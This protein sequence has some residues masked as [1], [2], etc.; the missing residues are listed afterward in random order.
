MPGFKPVAKLRPTPRSAFPCCC[1]MFFNFQSGGE[2]GDVLLLILKGRYAG[3][4]HSPGRNEFIWSRLALLRWVSKFILLQFVGG[5][6]SI[7]GP[8]APTA[9]GA[10][11]SIL[12]RLPIMNTQETKYFYQ[13]PRFIDILSSANYTLEV[14]SRKEPSTFD[15]GVVG[16]VVKI[17]LPLEGLECKI[18]VGRGHR[19]QHMW[20]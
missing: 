13:V 12:H 6:N 19:S 8:P 3:L 11:A 20:Q 18:L 16:I 17:D 1:L 9:Y 14:N 10:S 2:S 4:I 5:H 15:L 7:S